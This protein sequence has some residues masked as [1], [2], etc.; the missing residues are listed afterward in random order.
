MTQTLPSDHEADRVALQALLDGQKTQD[1]R[2]RLGQFATPT[3]LARA[4][5]HASLALLPADV[6]V[7]FLDPAIG[8]G[9]FYAALRA[10]VPQDRIAAAQGYEIDPHYAAPAQT[11]WQDTPLHIA[12]ADFTHLPAPER[13]AQRYNLLL[14]NP[15]YV[16]HHHL[17]HGEKARLQGLAHVS[18]GMHIG[19][20]AGLYCYFLALAHGWMQ[21]GALACWLLP[22]EFMTVNY[23][24]AVK[25]YLLDTVTLLRIHRF[26]PHDVQF[27][28]ALVSSAV[29]FFR[30][31]PPPAD[32]T[33]TC[34]YGG[35]LHAPA[36]AKNIAA[37]DLH[38][39]AKWT[40]FPVADVR[41][42]TTGP[43]INNFFHIT[44]GI[45]TGDNA[46]FILTPAQIQQHDLPWACFRPILPSPRYLD[47]EEVLADAQ[48]NPVGVRP[49]FLL[50]CPLPEHTIQASYPHLWTYLQSGKPQVSSR[51]LC[52]SRTPWYRQE[53]R[54][55][56][57]FACTYLGRNN[58]KRGKP[59]RFILNHSQ[60]TAANVYLL[61]Y[62]TPVLAKALAAN[63]TFVRTVWHWL[64]AIQ[65]TELLDEGRVYG[66]GL[67]KL[68][69]KELARVKADELHALLSGAVPAPMIQHDLFGATIC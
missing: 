18:A 62:P 15:P 29:V 4:M 8:T 27:V 37:V 20:L 11:L 5:L 34:S 59:F 64:N 51:Y 67:H 21:Q 24:R 31:E 63:P 47:D 16:R 49:L 41:D 61:L 55:A 19:G 22:S 9:A 58:T 23:G 30:N 6:P 60:A 65:S 3:A 66:G 38:R 43:T 1:E 46:F 35:T 10:T 33:V 28:D 7:R 2:N 17:V 40:R 68:E 56:P 52:T 54:P 12:Q 14:C 26:D 45:A 53:R 32:H 25:D 57:L 42:A 50:D 44:R 48:G 69:P 36:L 39:E 13:E